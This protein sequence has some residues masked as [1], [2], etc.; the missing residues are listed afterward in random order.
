MT[1]KDEKAMYPE[2]LGI[3]NTPPA[4]DMLKGKTALVTGGGSGIGKAIANRL[5]Q[6]G[7]AVVIC[8][9]NKNSLEKCCAEA[10]GRDI[11]WLV[12][13][14]SHVEEQ[15]QKLM[16]AEKLLGENIDILVNNAGMISEGERRGADFL[17]ILPED[18]DSV[19]GLNMKGTYFMCQN[20]V[21]RCIHHGKSGKIIN[22]CSVTGLH[23]R[24][25][26]YPISKN[27]II[28]FTR[29][30]APMIARYGVTIN[31][32]AP[33]LT[34]TDLVSSLIPDRNNIYRE[35]HPDKRAAT[36]DEIANIALFL[37]SEYSSHMS[38]SVLVCDGGKLYE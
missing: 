13:D 29:A 5:S 24:S 31:G 25:K 18:W 4:S 16:E 22:I 9:R 28:Y 23:P 3:K 30:L 6:A 17:S 34:S 11:R 36:P 35:D 10:A 21:R 2:E 19:M 14:V 33:G 1:E 7:A 26:P 8:G 32:I 12:M 20:Y 37:S 27:G 15:E 38:G